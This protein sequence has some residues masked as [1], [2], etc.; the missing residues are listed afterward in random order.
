MELN[1]VSL[2]KYGPMLNIYLYDTNSVQDRLFQRNQPGSAEVEQT[3]ES[4][5]GHSDKDLPGGNH[6]EK[7]TVGLPHSIKNGGEKS[8]TRYVI[9]EHLEP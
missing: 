1:Q 8:P 7:T 6:N 2:G 3:V 5:I 9:T 4:K